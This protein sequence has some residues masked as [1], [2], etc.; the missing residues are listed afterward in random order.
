MADDFGALLVKALRRMNAGVLVLMFGSPE[1]R[2]PVEDLL[3]GKLS[4]DEAQRVRDGL[5][6]VAHKIA[7]EEPR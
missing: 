5:D 1:A 3:D 7:G 2:R 4:R 6:R